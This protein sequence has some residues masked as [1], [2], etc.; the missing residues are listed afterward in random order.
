MESVSQIIKIEDL[1]F[2]YRAD[3]YLF[4]NIGGTFAGV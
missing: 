3:V 1:R 4:E 2:S